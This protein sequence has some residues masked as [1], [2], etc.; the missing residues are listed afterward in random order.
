M[1]PYPFPV[2][3][4]GMNSLR[5]IHID[6]FAV[7]CGVESPPITG[8]CKEYSQLEQEEWFGNGNEGD[9]VV[10]QEYPNFERVTLKHAD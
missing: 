6:P 9:W 8:Y 3:N 5:E 7:N 1:Q 2:A 4:D 10:L